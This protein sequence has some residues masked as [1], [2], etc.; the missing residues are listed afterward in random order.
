M[1]IKQYQ[2]INI[3]NIKDF[4]EIIE[5]SKL[6]EIKITGQR[7]ELKWHKIKINILTAF[8]GFKLISNE[9]DALGRLKTGIN[10]IMFNKILE[11]DNIYIDKDK[12][13]CALILIIN[14]CNVLSKDLEFFS[15]LLLSEKLNK[16]K[17]DNFVSN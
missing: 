15:N 7:K 6:F 16:E 1:E 12:L 9:Q 10:T 4:K 14:P 11:K 3:L 13:E 2:L 8:S 5:Y 17:I